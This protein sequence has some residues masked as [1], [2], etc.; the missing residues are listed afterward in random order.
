MDPDEVTGRA[1]AGAYFGITEFQLALSYRQ[2]YA[3]SPNQ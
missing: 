3:G 1:L 2:C